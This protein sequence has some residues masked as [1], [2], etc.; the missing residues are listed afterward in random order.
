MCAY[1]YNNDNSKTEVKY[2]RKTET[3]NENKLASVVSMYTNN[4][5]IHLQFMSM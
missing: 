2:A 5:S 3:I 4:L 1:K